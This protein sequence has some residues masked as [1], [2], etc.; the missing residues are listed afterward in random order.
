MTAR[1]YDTAT[2]KPFM[3]PSSP[4]PSMVAANL[5]AAS[6]DLAAARARMARE[7]T[8][9]VERDLTKMHKDAV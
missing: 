3:G 4:V 8:A 9:D 1:C 6:K 5:A 2:G 7:A